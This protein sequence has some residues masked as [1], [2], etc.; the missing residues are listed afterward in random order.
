MQLVS[1]RTHFLN[2]HKRANETILE[3]MIPFQI[4][5]THA[6]QDKITNI[7]VHSMMPAVIPLRLMLLCIPKGYLRIFYLVDYI[8]H[9]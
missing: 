9:I 4:D 2:N 1:F 5:L 7:E 6:Q 8:V 3:H